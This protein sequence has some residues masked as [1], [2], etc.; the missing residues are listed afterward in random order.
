[1]NREQKYTADIIMAI[2]SLFDENN[3]NYKYS[4]NS[5][6]G[7]SFFTGIIMAHLYLYKELVD[8][9]CDLLDNVAI[10]NKLTFQY[11]QK[12]KEEPNEH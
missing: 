3:E 10:I 1:M 7:T 5:L 9:K 6:D 2:N 8:D 11:L 4:L 12:V